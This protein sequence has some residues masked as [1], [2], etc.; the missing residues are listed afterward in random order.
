MPSPW[1]G[2]E[3]PR[4]KLFEK[5]LVAKNIFPP[6]AGQPLYCGGLEN[7][8]GGPFLRCRWAKTWPK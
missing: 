6:S 5:V 2:S 8:V 7:V 1:K 4:R 3:R